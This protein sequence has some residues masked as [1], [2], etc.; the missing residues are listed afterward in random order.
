MDEDNHPD[1]VE[2][3]YQPFLRP[4]GNMVISFAQA[5]NALKEFLMDLKGGDERAAIMLLGRDLEEVIDVI[6][7]SGFQGFELEDLTNH[8]KEFWKAKEE[9][10]RL[11]HDD[12]WVGLDSDER[13]RVGTNGLPKKKGS[14]MQWGA[15]TCEAIWDLARQFVN[16]RL[17][18][19][20]YTDIWRHR[21]AS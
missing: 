2:V 3:F 16:H 18:F 21:R 20:S 9:R 7:A 12:W 13:P 11:I 1:F 6:R 5:E 19:S 17:V 4:L 8:L 14:V 15:P 10:N